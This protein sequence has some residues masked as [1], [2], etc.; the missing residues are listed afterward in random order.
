M[1]RREFFRKTVR[2]GAAAGAAA[3]L[4]KTDFLFGLDKPA[5]AL[6]MAAVRG[7]EPE[8]MFDAGIAAFGGMGNFVKKGQTVLV[9][10]NIGWAVEPEMAAT[11]NP[12]LITRIIEHCLEAG[13]KKVTVFDHSCDNNQE[14]YKKSGIEKAARDA[15]AIIIPGEERKYYQKVK[16]PGASS[17]PDAEVHEA[18]ME[19]D[20]FINVPVLKS[21]SST[22]LT[23]GMKN[24]MGVVYNRNYW[25]GDL[26]G[27]IVDFAKFRKPDLTVVDAYAVMKQYGPRGLQGNK[28]DIL[29]NLLIST[30]IVLADAAAAKIFGFSDPADISHIRLAH[31]RHVGNMSTEGRNIKRISL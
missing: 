5:S 3:I 23:I 14:S 29:K 1:D 12:G 18:F 20:V 6:E 22:Q 30:D 19:A 10:P 26:D 7:G 28:P 27:C 31:E 24:L 4:S 9:K 17:L 8:A 11:T 2:I 15:G 21:H 16:I 13:A 25:H